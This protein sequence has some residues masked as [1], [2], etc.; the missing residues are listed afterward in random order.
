VHEGRGAGRWGVEG[1]RRRRSW[2][3]AGASCEGGAGAGARPLRSS[4]L[5]AG[6]EGNR[7]RRRR[8]KQLGRRAWRRR[9][10]VGVGGEGYLGAVDGKGPTAGFLVTMEPGRGHEC[11]R[12]TYD[13]NRV[14]MIKELKLLSLYFI[15]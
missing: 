13:L 11:G 1:A 15:L 3:E 12:F 5:A 14:V 8:G 2:G 7:G 9:K 10:G 6:E 4:D